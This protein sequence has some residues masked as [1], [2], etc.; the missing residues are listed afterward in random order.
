MGISLHCLESICG[1]K[2]KVMCRELVEKKKNNRGYV[3]KTVE[4]FKY[5][6]SFD[7][8]TFSKMF[9]QWITFLI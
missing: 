8:Q 9:V 1:E 5:E 7:F 4:N 6:N 2:K 3:Y